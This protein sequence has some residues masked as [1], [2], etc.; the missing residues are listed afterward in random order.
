MLSLSNRGRHV[1]V[2]RNAVVQLLRT[3]PSRIN[4]VCGVHNSSAMRLAISLVRIPSN[5]RH[6]Y[7]TRVEWLMLMMNWESGQDTRINLKD[8]DKVEAIPKCSI[9]YMFSLFNVQPTQL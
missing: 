1:G 9:N 7:S 2:V 6:T 3:I 8:W 4:G 5:R